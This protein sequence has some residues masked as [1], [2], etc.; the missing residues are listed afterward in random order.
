MLQSNSL[1]RRLLAYLAPSY[2]KLALAFLA[3]IIVAATSAAHAWLIDPVINR[4]FIEKE[5]ELLY[6]VTCGLLVIALLKSIASY[7]QTM[8][9]KV[10]GQRMIT[11]LQLELYRRLVYADLAELEK[12]STGN[13]ISHFTNDIHIIR[14]SIAYVF[15]S[16]A[17]E[18]LTIIFLVGLMFYQNWLLATIA[19]A[20]FPT[21]IV[22]ITRVSRKMRR[23]AAQTQLELSNY[24]S[25]LD[26]TFQNIRIVKSFRQEENEVARAERLVQGIFR[27]LARASRTES[28][29]SPIME[30][31]TGAAIAIIVAIGGAQVISGDLTAGGFLSTITA[32]IMAY[33]PVKSLAEI[34]TRTQEGLA[35]AERIFHLLD[36][37]PHIISLPAAPDLRISHGKVE[38]SQVSFA[39]EQQ[40]T[41]DNVSFVIEGGKTVAIVGSSGGGKST[42]INLLLRF[43]Q[44][45]NGRILIDGQDISQV[46]LATLRDQIAL[47][48]QEIILFDDTV[49]ANIAYSKYNATETEI[50]AAAKAAAAHDFIMGLPE[51]YNTHIG[52]AGL[53][54]SGGQRQRLA[55]ARALL[56]NSPI[57]LLD[58]ATA[59]LDN[60]SEQQI[61]ES[62]SQLRKERTIIMVA[63]RLSTVINADLILV[64]DQGRVVESGTHQELLAQQGLYSKLYLGANED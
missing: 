31:L 39:Y 36:L 24:T 61:Q 29:S 47:V 26:D 27:L 9:V 52:Q 10:V 23:I 34:N 1:W 51:Q 17:R 56:K 40:L 54:L 57:L 33:R 49:K 43:Y 6:L 18:L 38:F 59:A 15:V 12:F 25:K 14:H 42:I 45:D 16:I 19:C 48:T 28:L 50:I 22:P 4:I 64:M 11:D 32:I 60:L 3:M 21:A 55:I 8:L 37:Q 2:V 35:A 62:F 13:L 41:L 46:S 7:F 30:L 44:P 53:K 63:H 58:E 20:V 5:H